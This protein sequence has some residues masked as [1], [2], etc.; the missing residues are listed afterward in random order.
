M[1]YG[2]LSWIW[3][4]FTYFTRVEKRIFWAFILSALL[5]ILLRAAFTSRK[6]AQLRED[7]SQAFSPR[8][9]LHASTRVD[10]GCLFFNNWLK[11]LVLVPLLWNTKEILIWFAHTLDQL[12]GH[13]FALNHWPVEVVTALYTLT[14]FI[15]SDASRYLVHY[16]LHRIPWLWRFHKV[17]HSAEVLTP[18]TV[19]RAHPVEMFLYR[20]RS[21]LVVGGVSGLFFYLFGGKMQ[22][23]A[24][25]GI[26]GLGFLF[27]FFGS[28]LRHS[29]V[30]MGFGPLEHIFI[31][32]AQHQMHHRRQLSLATSNL[33]SCLA[34]W[35]R[36]F[37]TFK[38]SHTVAPD[39]RRDYGL[40]PD[41]ANH[42]AES[43]WS[44]VIQPFYRP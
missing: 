24:I 22:I 26:N 23:W 36:L 40:Q 1:P 6:S 19:Y 12:F 8:I 42:R 30:W 9:W 29:Q 21:L 17:H 4:P 10:I 34:I 5:L 15:C 11:A 3:A 31:S 13:K 32:P 14:L 27:N 35:D 38:R 41:R 7:L 28:N 16:A 18:L 44:T 20:L 2:D 33:G 25:F 39:Q 37:G 43:W